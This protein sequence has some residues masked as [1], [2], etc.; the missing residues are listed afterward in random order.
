VIEL[1]RQWKETGS[2]EARRQGGDRRSGRVEVHAAEILALLDETPDISLVEIG[3]HLLAAHGERF[4]PSVLCRF[5]DRHDIT[6][7]KNRARQRADT[8]G[9][10]RGAR[11]LAGPAA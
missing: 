2:C 10:G 8:A 9:R 5:F 7:K 11:R 3:D 1:M 4:V 6:V